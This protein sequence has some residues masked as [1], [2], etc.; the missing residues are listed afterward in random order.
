MKIDWQK[1][2]VK[3]WIIW[4]AVSNRFR[5]SYIANVCKHH[6]KR[7]GSTVSFGERYVTGMPLEDNGNP[8]Y[9]LECVGKMAIRCGWCGKPIHIGYNVTP[10]IPKPDMP[11]Y[12]VFHQDH[13]GGP[14]TV[15]G[16][17]RITCAETGADYHGVWVPPGKVE[18]YPSVIERLAGAVEAGDECPIVMIK[19]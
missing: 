14:V 18:R 13:I 9:C 16:C 6:T 4:F 7:E 19:S 15:V 17:P 12:T 2:K 10:Y 5:K 1:V 3:L 11:K 8:D